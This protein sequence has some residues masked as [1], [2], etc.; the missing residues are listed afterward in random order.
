M[1]YGPP[2]NS[3]FGRLTASQVESRQTPIQLPWVDSS[4]ADWMESESKAMELAWGPA[5]THGPL[6]F[7]HIPLYAALPIPSLF[8]STDFSLSLPA[9]L[10]RHFKRA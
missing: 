4:V 10:Y 1:W 9:M 2:P 7:M 3:V 6:A 5:D 8:L